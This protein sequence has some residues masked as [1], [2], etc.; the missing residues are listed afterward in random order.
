M[1]TCKRRRSSSPRIRRATSWWP[2]TT[3]RRRKDH[4]LLPA[5]K[6]DSSCE[7]IAARTR[8]S[9]STRTTWRRLIFKNILLRM[10]ANAETDRAKQDALIKE[11]DELRNK[12]MELN[13]RKAS[14]KS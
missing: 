2:P 4:R 12:A 1:E 11:A 13:K 8:R 5:Q 9:R 10:Q 3:G 14:G 7:G 6:K